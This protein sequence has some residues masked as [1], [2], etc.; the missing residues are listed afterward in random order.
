[1]RTT[2]RRAFL[3]Y[4][5][6]SAAA[7]PILLSACQS[8]SS[9]GG[10]SDSPPTAPAAR[11][12]E[13]SEPEAQEQP[14]GEPADEQTGE[15]QT[16]KLQVGDNIQ[17]STNRIEVKSGAPV[18]VTLEHTGKLAKEAMGHNFVLLKKGTDMN[19][20]AN[21]AMGAVENGYIPPNMADAV[22]A[23]TKLVGGGESDTITFPAPAPGEYVYL[24]TFPG[25]YMNMN[26]KLIVS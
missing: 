12:P 15:P 5:L 13:P 2:D 11:A 9:D 8:G 4:L 21:A 10:P 3:G 26:G 25:H 23:H 17:Y 19:A 20:F 6:S 14:P 18:E 7:T 22:I 24:C 1:M 16:V